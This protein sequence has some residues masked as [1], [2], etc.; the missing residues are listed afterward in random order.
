MDLLRFEGHIV[1]ASFASGDTLVAGRWHGSPFGPFADLM[2]RRA[3]G[4]RVLIA[5]TEEIRGFVGRHYA[6]DEL[7]GGA[8][9]VE[10]EGDGAISVTADAASMRLEPG[11]IDVAGLL[12]RL[13]PRWLRSRRTWVAVED[14]VLR[15]V[16]SRL[17]GAGEVR[18]RGRTRAGAR[19]WY[20]IHDVRPAAA[21]ASVGTED[22]GAAVPARAPA[23][24][25][26]SEFPSR[27][28]IVRVTSLIEA[29]GSGAPGQGSGGGSGDM[30]GR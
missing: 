6:F 1:G 25:G 28:S 23:G 19:E 15:P 14:S 10:R 26:F 7:R 18:T 24:F 16:V 17:V 27:P 4:S 2:W 5:P 30:P 29:P 20:V 12:V 22:L 13:R 11:A 8:V 9:R 21:T 3:D